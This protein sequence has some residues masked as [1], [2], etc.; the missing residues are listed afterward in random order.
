MWSPS[1]DYGRFLVEHDN[2]IDTFKGGKH[3]AS[4]FLRN[5]RPFIT[6]ERPDGAVGVEADDQHIA[7]PPRVVQVGDM[8]DVQKVKASVGEYDTATGFAEFVETFRKCFNINNF[9]RC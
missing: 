3:V 8:A 1:K 6:F 9:I 2:E 4:L 5:D 7:E